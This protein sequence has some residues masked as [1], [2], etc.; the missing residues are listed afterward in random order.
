M[1]PVVKRN[2]DRRDASILTFQPSGEVTRFWVVRDGLRQYMAPSPIFNAV[3]KG[4]IIV[5]VGGTGGR[6][7][8]ATHEATR[9]HRGNTP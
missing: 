7:R 3:I 9:S 1:T 4:G 5:A 8:E 6:I 2:Q